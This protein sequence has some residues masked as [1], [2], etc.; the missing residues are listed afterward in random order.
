MLLNIISILTHFIKQ[1]T[2]C[3]MELLSE[4]QV[5]H[6]FSKCLTFPHL[7]HDCACFNAGHSESFFICSIS[8]SLW[9]ILVLNSIHWWGLIFWQLLRIFS[10]HDLC[11]FICKFCC[12]GSAAFFRSMCEMH[13]SIIWSL[14]ISSVPPP[15]LQ[16]FLLHEGVCNHILYDYIIWYNF[17]W[18]KISFFLDSWNLDLNLIW[19]A[20]TTNFNGLHLHRRQIG[21]TS[22]P[23]YCLIITDYREQ[24]CYTTLKVNILH[25][26][27]STTNRKHRQYSKY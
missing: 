23:M 3:I 9:F 1:F 20:Y 14:N 10:L 7:L 11:L 25:L 18:Y 19:C 24:V 8:N 16:Y 21:L 13:F 22:K 26:T 12:L 17:I 15:K 4:F 2:L 27:T 5:L 6:I